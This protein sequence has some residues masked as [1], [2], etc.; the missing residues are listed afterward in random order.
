M[1]F[2][3]GTKNFQDKTK[4]TQCKTPKPLMHQYALAK[5]KERVE[6]LE[7]IFCSLDCFRKW[8]D[9]QQALAGLQQDGPG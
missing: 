6:F 3:R 2:S 4:C 8:D 1:I 9:R 5:K 7:E